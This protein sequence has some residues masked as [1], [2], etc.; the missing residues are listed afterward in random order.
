MEAKLFNATGKFSF[1][2]VV[3]AV[4]SLEVVG[5]VQQRLDD[6]LEEAK[7]ISVQITTNKDPSV[8]PGR[9][10]SENCLKSGYLLRRRPNRASERIFCVLKPSTKL[11][12]FQTPDD[13]EPREVIDIER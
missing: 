6:W 7:Q 4:S 9:V 12:L 11:Y 8:T 5:S 10:M 3:N 13:V 1:G 2:N